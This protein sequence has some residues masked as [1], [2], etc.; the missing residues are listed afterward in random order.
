[1]N[2]PYTVIIS[3]K[4]G[5]VVGMDGNKYLMNTGEE[6]EINPLE[7]ETFKQFTLKKISTVLFH[8]GGNEWL[9]DGENLPALIISAHMEIREKSEARTEMKTLD[10]LYRKLTGLSFEDRE[11]VKGV[12][13][14]DES[15]QVFEAETAESCQEQQD[16]WESKYAPGK[17]DAKAPLPSA[18]GFRPVLLTDFG[19]GSGHKAEADRLAASG[20]VAV[21]N[22]ERAAK[23]IRDANSDL[24]SSTEQLAEVAQP[25][26]EMYKDPKLGAAKADALKAGIP[27]SVVDVIVSIYHKSKMPTVDGLVKYLNSGGFTTKLES[28]G[29]GTSRPTIGRWLYEFKKIMRRR[30]LIH[31][32]RSPKKDLKDERVDI[33]AES[34]DVKPGADQS[35]LTAADTRAQELPEQSGVDES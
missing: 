33:S 31:D 7:H 5:E 11:K 25:F 13:W 20:K 30:G 24:R 27:E 26:R 28:E 14:F 35:G 6:L 21:S 34:D 19:F 17:F 9:V 32:T 23:A 29:L 10:R 12:A 4:R 8:N 22:L 18:K 16:V 3:Q 15:H 2:Y 1:M